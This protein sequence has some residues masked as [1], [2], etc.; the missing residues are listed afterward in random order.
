M[1]GIF[2]LKCYFILDFS[3]FET[4]SLYHLFFGARSLGHGRKTLWFPARPKW[5][6]M[7]KDRF[8]P[9][10]GSKMRNWKKKN[11][12]FCPRNE[13]G[14]ST[15]TWV[16]QRLL[17]LGKCKWRSYQ[18]RPYPSSQHPCGLYHWKFSQVIS[19]FLSLCLW[20]L[21]WYGKK[22]TEK[23]HLAADEVN[24]IFWGGANCKKIEVVY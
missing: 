16:A 17:G 15:H 14:I 11:L 19:S 13:P 7:H 22:L 6:F 3:S 1:F 23:L 5:L 8:L 9:A 4:V 24:G 20:S 10:L 2:V 21:G 18:T 12:V